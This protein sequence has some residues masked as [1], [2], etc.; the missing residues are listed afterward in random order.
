MLKKAKRFLYLFHRWLGV[1]LCLWFV[2]L[3]A[4]GVVMMYVEYPELT[5]EE[6][7]WQLQP[8]DAAAV[9]LSVDDALR[10][11]G[12]TNISTVTLANVLGRPAYQFSADSGQVTTVFADTGA[13]LGALHADDALVAARES[14]FASDTATPRYD[15]AIHV[16]QW[17]VTSSLN[18]HRP[19]HRVALEDA[20]GTVLYI[21]DSNGRVV[22]DTNRAERFWNWLGS[23]IHWIYPWQFR[24]HANLWIDVLTYLSLAGVLSVASGAVVGWWR[25]RLKRKYRGERITPYTGWQKWHHVLGLGCLLFLSTWIFSGLMSMLPWGIFDNVTSTEEPLSRYHGGA[26]DGFSRFPSLQTVWQQSAEPVKEVEWRRI[27]ATHY[28]VASHSATDKTVLLPKHAVKHEVNDDALH[29]LIRQQAPSLL[30]Q[31]NVVEQR[32]IMQYDSWYYTHHNRYRPLPALE[33]RFDDAEQSWYHIDL[34][35]GAVVQ[36]LTNTDRWARWLYNGLHSLDF[37]PLFQYRPLWDVT[38]ILLLICGF[39][40]TL[41]AVVIGW[42]RLRA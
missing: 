19:L 42:R 35:T 11:A 13:M 30:P 16:D 25:L 40:F 17:T 10:N 38:L 9:R 31:A 39:A 33:V 34:S 41:T 5:E 20:A 2:L 29:A 15:G 23:T 36:R 8:L 1:V 21:S 12:A 26:V 32:V 18:V 3:F 24:Q 37:A 14:G 7:L 28:L 27:G 6:R 22:R 4:S